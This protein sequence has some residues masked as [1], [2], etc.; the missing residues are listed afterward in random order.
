MKQRPLSLTHLIRQPR[1]AADTPPLLVL[2][3]G[4]GSNERDL[5]G[6]AEYLDERFLV[7][8]ARAPNTRM[9]GSYAWFEIAFTPDGMV[10]DVDQAERSLQLL[11]RFVEEAVEAYAADPRRVYLAGFSQG[12]I[13]SA[14][15]ALT[16]PDLVDGVVLMS[17]RVPPEILPAIAPVEQLEGLHF[18]V[19]HG[20]YDNTLP[21]EYGRASRDILQT[22]P[23]D[24]S[25]NEYPMGHEVSSASLTDVATWLTNR[26]DNREHI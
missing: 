1:V 25:Y 8:S 21:I 2:L 16:R 11:I 26:L 17:G 24:L 20:V 9:P 3:H 22:L 13:M 15:V 19:V 10:I 7:L 4:I 23:V 18:L 6:L 14:C 5:F 12:A